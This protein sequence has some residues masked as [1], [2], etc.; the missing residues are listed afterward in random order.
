MAAEPTLT[1]ADIVTRT[2]RALPWTA[3]LMMVPPG[4]GWNIADPALLDVALARSAA[5]WPDVSDTTG[6]TLWWYG[7]SSTVALVLGAQILVTGHC[8]DPTAPDAVTAIGDTGTVAALTSPTVAPSADT[9]MADLVERM[10][11]GLAQRVPGLSAPSLWAI[12]SD[13]VANRV[14]DV[15][16]ALGRVADA[17]AAARLLTSQS[18]THRFPEP[19]F[20]DVTADAIVTPA[21]GSAPDA[22]S[23]RVVRRGSCC[24]V[25]EAGVDM[26]V[27]CPRRAP[28]DRARR[29]SALL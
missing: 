12:A 29:W 9:A 22:H 11:G 3:N 10:V 6:A 2:A 28:E 23:R 19:R 8:V 17:T 7:S 21:T 5:R 14:L 15:A 25:F 24:L 4:D 13:S 26:C 20:V 27:S 16:S 18:R 1:A